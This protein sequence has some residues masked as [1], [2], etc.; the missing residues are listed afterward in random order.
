MSPLRLAAAV[1]CLGVSLAASA[2]LAPVAPALDPAAVVRPA[3]P[4]TASP[5]ATT[6]DSLATPDATLSAPADETET[7]E[8]PFLFVGE[9]D[10]VSRLDEILDAYESV[11]SLDGAAPAPMPGAMLFADYIETVKGPKPG[12]P[13]PADPTPTPFKVGVAITNPNATNYIVEFFVNGKARRPYLGATGAG[14]EIKVGARKTINVALSVDLGDVVTA[15][16]VVAQRAL[17]APTPAVVGVLPS[18]K[19]LT[20]DGVKTTVD[21]MGALRLVP[22][23]R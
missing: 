2:D 7:I 14:T 19:E 10:D 9:I 20:I 12:S 22:G 6:V 3:D 4:V 18:S 5:I 13:M 23:R 17:K 1:F 11:Q 8:V 15:K 21:Y 16:Y